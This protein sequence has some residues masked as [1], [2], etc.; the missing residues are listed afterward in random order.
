MGLLRKED[1]KYLQEEFKKKLKRKVELLYFTNRN[2]DSEYSSQTRELFEELV[3][4]NDNLTLTIKDCSDKKEFEEEGLSFCPAIKIKSDRKGFINFY[5]TPAGY[6]FSTFIEDI[7][8]KGS[9]N[10]PLSYDVARELKK[11][12]EPVDLKVF[13]TLNCPYCPRAVRI[14]HLFSLVNENIKS[15]MIDVN[16]FP[17]LSRDLQISS[18]P[19]TIV[20]GTVNFLG[21]LPEKKFLAKLEEAIK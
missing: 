15:S 2:D 4:L 3:G 14:A 5:G 9:D 1:R 8:D 18:V 13:I 20:N 17:K 12:D 19:L 16:I 10:L 7:I 6:E 21:A 11:I